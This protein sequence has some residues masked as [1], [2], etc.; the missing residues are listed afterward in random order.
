MDTL[1]HDRLINR[2]ETA[3]H[4]ARE[5]LRHYFD[6][7]GV[8]VRGDVAGEIDSIIDLIVEAAET[9]AALDREGT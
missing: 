1:T 8:P 7:A 4:K 9:G 3:M 6:L 2:R 5:L